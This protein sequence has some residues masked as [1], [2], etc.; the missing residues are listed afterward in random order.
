MTQ[1]TR[2]VR[3]NVSVSRLAYFLY[4]TVIKRISWNS[5]WSNVFLFFRSR[6]TWRNWLFSFDHVLDG[7]FD[8]FFVFLC[9]PV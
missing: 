8:F 5:N 9:P 3:N 6:G 2:G 7:P 4:W 1:D